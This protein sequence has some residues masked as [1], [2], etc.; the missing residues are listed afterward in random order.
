MGFDSSRSS[1]KQSRAEL[2]NPPLILFPNPNSMVPGAVSP[3]PE[4][5]GGSSKRATDAPESRAVSYWGNGHGD[6]PPPY[7]PG[8]K[9]MAYHAASSPKPGAMSTKN[10]AAIAAGVLAVG[11]VTALGIYAGH[12]HDEAHR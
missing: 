8:E 12:E 11:G 10:K 1:Q 7:T 5:A 4:P 9:G 3:A 6:A 2:S